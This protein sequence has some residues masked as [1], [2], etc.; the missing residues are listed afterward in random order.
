[1]S[2]PRHFGLLPNELAYR[3]ETA[4][5]DLKF[6]RRGADVNRHRLPLS[7]ATQPSI[8]LDEKR[9]G[10]RCLDLRDEEKKREYA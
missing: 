8:S 1:M 9:E 6:R 4:D 2:L 5:F 10:I 3:T 7:H